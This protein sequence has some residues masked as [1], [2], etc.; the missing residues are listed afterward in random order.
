MAGELLFDSGA[1]VSLLD[2]SQVDHRACMRFF[3]GGDGAVVF[4]RDGARLLAE[5]L[6]TDLDFTTDRRDFSVYR[7]G[8]RKR[9]RIVP[10]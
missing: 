6:D 8:G 2:R 10:G 4:P 1:L 5:E 9:F 3:D 7:I